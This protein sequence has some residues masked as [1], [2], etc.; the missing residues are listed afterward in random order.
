MGVV[1]LVLVVLGASAD[2]FSHFKSAK[3]NQINPQVVLQEEIS[4]TTD[5]ISEQSVKTETQDQS[6]I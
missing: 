1:L 3:A 5:A 4:T 6:K 2:S